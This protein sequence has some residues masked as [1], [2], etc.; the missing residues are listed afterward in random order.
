VESEVTEPGLGKRR[1]E[2]TA[3]VEGEGEVEGGR[4]CWGVRKAG[5]NKAGD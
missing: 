4:G 3:A 2:K 5:L 1:R